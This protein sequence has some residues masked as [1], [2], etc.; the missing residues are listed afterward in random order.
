MLVYHKLFAFVTIILTA[1]HALAYLLDGDSTGFHDQM[2]TGMISF[3]GMMA[4]YILSLNFIRR[5]FFDVFIRL[6]WL[7]FFVMAFFT[8]VHGAPIIFVGLIP[9]V[10]DMLFRVIY[11]PYKYANGSPFKRSNSTKRTRGVVSREQV[12]ICALPGDITRISFLRINPHDTNESFEF[13]AGQYASPSYYS[14][15]RSVF[16]QL[17]TKQ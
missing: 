14:G 13:E 15:I 6:H 12:K 5:K 9:W 17:L 4:M 16:L 8:V 3:M 11:R 2:V 7:L 1:L 10:I